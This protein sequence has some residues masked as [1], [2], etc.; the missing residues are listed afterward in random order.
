[1]MASFKTVL[2]LFVGLQAFALTSSVKPDDIRID[3]D[4]LK[5]IQTGDVCQDCTEIFE[6][7]ED[8]LSNKHIQEKIV[9]FLVHV[10]ADLPGSST[11]SKICEKQVKKMLPLAINMITAF[12]QPEEICETL[13]ACHS[14]KMYKP[15]S[16]YARTPEADITTEHKFFL[17]CTICQT[18]IRTVEGLLP[19]DRTEETVAEALKKA[20]HIL[21]FGIAEVC[22][23][24]VG[25]YFKQVVD[26]LLEHA[27]PR[28]ICMAIDMCGLFKETF[29]E[30]C[31]TCSPPFSGINDDALRM[32]ASSNQGPK[33]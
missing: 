9:D 25:K 8:L 4:V 5:K 7:L 3:Q 27:A 12:I 30:K 18:I 33:P 14:S 22:D 15:L 32:F 19:K 24:I 21:P 10:C 13:K 11:L 17:T 20:C 31:E 2:L 6:L 16:L 1:M 23:E 28:V 26:L 29:V